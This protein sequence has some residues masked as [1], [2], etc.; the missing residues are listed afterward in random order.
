[1]VDNFKQIWH[2]SLPF[3][4]AVAVFVVGVLMHLK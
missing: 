2:Q 1:M 4:I 3:R